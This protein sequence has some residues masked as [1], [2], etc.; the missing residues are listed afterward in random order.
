MNPSSWLLTLTKRVLSYILN[1]VLLH[2]LSRADKDS[3][4]IHVYDGRGSSDVLHTFDKLHNNPIVMMK[5]ICSRLNMLLKF[6]LYT[7]IC[8]IMIQLFALYSTMQ[9][10]T[11]QWNFLKMHLNSMMG[12]QFD[13]TYNSLPVFSSTG[14]N[15]YN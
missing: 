13:I 15:C 12:I 1:A 10:Y 9:F 11:R 5:V 8:C 14:H 6:F 7:L 3:N 2:L 4:S